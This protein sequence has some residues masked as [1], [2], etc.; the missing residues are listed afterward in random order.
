ME[1]F[2][3]DLSPRVLLAEDDHELRELLALVL[4][5]AGYQVV[6]CDNGLQLLGHLERTDDVAAVIS[7]LRMPGLGGLEV[8]ARHRHRS[9]Q[10]PFI[11]MTAFGDELT[12]NRARQLGAAEVINKPFDLDEM[13]ALVERVCLRNQETSGVKQ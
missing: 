12:H 8:L 9:R 11:C 4:E 10:C 7:D 3:L 6:Q 5:G 2:C 1:A 13:I